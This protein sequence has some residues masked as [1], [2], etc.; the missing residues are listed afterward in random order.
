MGGEAVLRSSSSGFGVL[1]SLLSARPVLCPAWDRSLHLLHPHFC[2][3]RLQ[4]RLHFSA[5]ML[6]SPPTH[7]VLSTTPP[8]WSRLHLLHPSPSLHAR[9]S[10]LILWTDASCTKCHEARDCAPAVRE[11]SPSGASPQYV[12]V[13]QSGN[14][15]RYRETVSLICSPFSLHQLLFIGF[16]VCVCH[17]ACPRKLRLQKIIIS[18]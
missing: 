10:R 11:V 18:G 14:R 16:C 3:H 1:P 6:L 13:A 2:R 7:L 17:D 15:A 9:R 12:L 5:H 8:T 4:L